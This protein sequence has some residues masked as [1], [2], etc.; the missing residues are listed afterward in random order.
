MVFSASSPFLET[1]NRYIQFL[2][3]QEVRDSRSRSRKSTLKIRNTRKYPIKFKSIEYLLFLGTF[4]HTIALLL[5]FTEVKWSKPS[6]SGIHQ[7]NRR[8]ILSVK[9]TYAVNE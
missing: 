4:C 1:S 7:Y 3:A 8:R 6:A 5:L 2:Y 9:Y